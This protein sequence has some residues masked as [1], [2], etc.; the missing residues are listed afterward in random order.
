M[1]FTSTG[2]GEGRGEAIESLDIIKVKLSYFTN[3]L[4]FSEEKNI[5]LSSM[6]LCLPNFRR[7]GGAAYEYIHVDK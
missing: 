4:P 5:F 1:W 6:L 7:G 2:G 3:F